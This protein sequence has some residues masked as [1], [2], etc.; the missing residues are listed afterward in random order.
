MQAHHVLRAR[1][2]GGDLVD[3]EIRG[4]G[5]QHGALLAHA[6][7]FGEHGLLHRHVLEHRFDHD[8]DVGQRVV[9]GGAVE[10]RHHRGLGLGRHAL[11]LDE[12]VVHLLDVGAAAREL[13]VVALDHGHGHAGVQHG[14][15]DA[16]AHGAAADDAGGRQRARLG[17]PGLGRLQHFALGEE[18]MDQAGALRAVDALQEQLAFQRHAFGKGQRERAFDGFDD[19]HRREQA[20][21]LLGGV[22]A[23]GVEG[24]A[25]GFG[26]GQAGGFARAAH[27]GLG[28]NQFLRVGQAFGAR[29]GVDGQAVDE[30]ERQ[31]FLRARVAAAQHQFQCRLHA[32]QARRALR[33]ARAGQQAQRHFGQ[34]QLGGGRGQAVV[35]RERH[36][37]PAAERGAV[38][39]GDHRLGAVLDRKAGLGQRGRLRR[40]AELADVRAGDEIAAGA[41]DQHRLGGAVGLGRVDGGHEAAAHIHAQGVDGR[42]VDGH[43]E[44]VAMT[45]EGDGTGRRGGAGGA[46]SGGGHVRVSCVAGPVHADAKRGARRLWG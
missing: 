41:D 9:A 16:C 39:R 30:A 36:F 11:L 45:L 40:L 7:E 34:A 20:P 46:G 26:I 38:D 2:A 35:R 43:H 24:G 25:A 27:G 12:A 29:V 6:V 13:G 3:V 18:G 23:R 19:L 8:V 14:H 1:N 10:A 21:A 4:V 28:G 5:G 31:R 15:G 37:E 44:H 22:G 33:A 32:D 42:V 17:R